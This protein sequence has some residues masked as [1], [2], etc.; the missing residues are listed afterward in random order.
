MYAN[1][2]MCKKLNDAI[3]CALPKLNN[4]II[5]CRKIITLRCLKIMLSLFLQIYKEIEKFIICIHEIKTYFVYI[6]CQLQQT[7][8]IAIK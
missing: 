5:I 6:V 1:S 7:Q 2:K 3:T 4:I 8:L